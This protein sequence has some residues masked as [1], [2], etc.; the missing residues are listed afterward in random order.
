VY[1]WVVHGVYEATVSIRDTMIGED[2]HPSHSVLFYHLR[3]IPRGDVDRR[4]GA[5]VG[6]HRDLCGAWYASERA[7]FFLYRERFPGV[8]LYKYHVLLLLHMV[9]KVWCVDREAVSCWVVF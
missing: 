1:P 9:G 3:Y 5:V 7:V 8:H 4:D 2:N 6:Y